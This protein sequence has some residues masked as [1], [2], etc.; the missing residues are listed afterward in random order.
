MNQQL[1]ALTRFGMQ[2]R[3]AL[4]Q[5]LNVQRE[6]D[7]LNRLATAQG[8]HNRLDTLESFTDLQ[9]QPITDEDTIAPELDGMTIAQ[10]RAALAALTA[11]SA[12]T[13]AT[14]EQDVSGASILST[15]LELTSL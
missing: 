14:S 15:A 12:F 13:L 1:P 11:L 6:A 8:I 3:T 10:Y 4:K 2:L 5:T 7:L 9:G